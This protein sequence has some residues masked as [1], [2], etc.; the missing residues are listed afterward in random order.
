MVKNVV[1]W[2][3]LAYSIFL[4]AF[5]GS[6]LFITVCGFLFVYWMF[7]WFYDE[8]ARSLT[9]FAALSWSAILLTLD[10]VRRIFK[11]K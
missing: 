6:D 8:L 11:N 4:V 1:F 10:Q 5:R 7:L 3:G 2:I 9:M